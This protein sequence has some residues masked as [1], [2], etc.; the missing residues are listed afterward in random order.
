MLLAG[1]LLASVLML[2]ALEHM[3]RQGLEG[4][5]LGTLIVPYCSGA[6]NL[7]FVLAIARNGGSGAEVITNA[8]VNNVTN[9]TVLLGLPALLWGLEVM[10]RG[11]VPKKQLRG[12][13]LSRLSLVLTLLAALAFGG[14]TWALGSD[15]TLS[16]GDGA[17]LVGL[18]LFW[19][20]VEV[21][22]VMRTNV[23]TDRRLGFLLLVDIVAI[24][25]AALVLYI[26]IEGL[27]HWLAGI[28]TG[29]VSYRNIGWLSGWLMVLPNAVPAFYYAARR[30][31]DVVYSS[32]IGDGHICIPLCIGLS[33]CLGAV[34]TPPLF[35][36]GLELVIGLNLAHL[37]LLLFRGRLGRFGGGALVLVYAVFVYRGLFAL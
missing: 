26:T 5:V 4:T 24:A 22:N 28:K 31:A 19:Q 30:R 7:F 36:L 13:R 9:L 3:A 35:R 14:I 32:Q 10:P 29:F 34:G 15:G 12:H 8:V 37:V 27:T 17:A 6:P 1:F 23:E 21:V 33:A 16:V 2:A 18:F 20:L 25:V 11:N